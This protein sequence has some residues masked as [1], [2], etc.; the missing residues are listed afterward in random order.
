MSLARISITIPEELVAAAD[1]RADA[2]ERSR[3]WVLVEA[4]RRYLAA[5]AGEVHEAEVVYAAGL[6]SSRSAQLAADLRLTPEERVL[7]A[8]ET[9][10]IDEELERGTTRC[11]VET[12]DRF[13]DY[14]EW[15]RREE[16]G[17]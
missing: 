4:L 14:L 3:S 11:R 17:V 1:R 8:E 16:L 5:P 12:F 10:R 15:K 7:A 13:E 2:L 6:G 9:S